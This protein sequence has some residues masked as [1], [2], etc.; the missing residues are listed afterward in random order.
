MAEAQ[1][2][3][4][5]KLLVAVLMRR[6]IAQDMSV[7]QE[8]ISK[9]VEHWGECDTQGRDHAFDLTNYY[10]GE[11]GTDLVR[12]LLAFKRLFPPEQIG[13]AKHICN[14]MEDGF[15]ATH[16]DGTRR[17]RFNLDIGY[18]DHA[19]LVLASMKVAGQKIYLGNGVYADPIARYEGGYYRPF[20]WS[21]P[22]FRDGRYGDELNAIRSTYLRQLRERIS[23]ATENR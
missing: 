17:R 15:A 18:L 23:G 1:A 8:L 5:V 13:M 2:A 10:E 9:L 20:P 4:P 6:E 22:D 12:R 21:F 16:A 19:K 3:E 7:W 11:M 14:T